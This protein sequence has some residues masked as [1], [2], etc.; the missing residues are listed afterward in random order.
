MPYGSGVLGRDS[1][2]TALNPPRKRDGV[3]HTQHLY[4]WIF[5]HVPHT[6]VDQA[7]PRDTAGQQPRKCRINK[8]RAS[9]KH[10]YKCW[11][12]LSIA[13]P[14]SARRAASRRAC[15]GLGS[16]MPTKPALTHPHRDAAGSNGASMKSFVL[17]GRAPKFLEDSRVT[18]QRQLLIS[19]PPWRQSRHG[20]RH[21]ALRNPTQTAATQL[22]CLRASSG[23]GHFSSRRARAPRPPSATKAP[24]NM[25]PPTDRRCNL[26]RT[27]H[28]F[29][30]RSRAVRSAGNEVRRVRRPGSGRG[31]G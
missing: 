10:E 17:K 6:R 22:V 28:P 12:Q 4:R 13:T 29:T 15:R 19:A 11:G 31:H 30:P 26:R 25:R 21:A 7:R 8:R 18:H 9:S 24:V 27:A 3:S 2:N 1:S 23:P 16:P 20:S 14:G 5:R